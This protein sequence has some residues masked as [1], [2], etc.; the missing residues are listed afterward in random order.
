MYVIV[1]D[2]AF[3]C[4]FNNNAVL[5]A[6]CIVGLHMHTKQKGLELLRL[7]CFTAGA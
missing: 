4:S 2:A 6:S 7:V 3:N 5:R 1:Y